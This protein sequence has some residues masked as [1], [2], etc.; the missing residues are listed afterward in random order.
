MRSKQAIS[1]KDVS[2]PLLFAD[3]GASGNASWFLR[4]CEAISAVSY[5]AASFAGAVLLDVRLCHCT[6]NSSYKAFRRS[7]ATSLTNQM[8]SL[9][10]RNWST[11]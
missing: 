9:L 5:T 4:F 10:V 7:S 1:A 3:F 2:F 8:E 11:G 6:Q